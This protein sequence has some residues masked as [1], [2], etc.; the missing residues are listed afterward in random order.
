MTKPVP[1]NSGGMIGDGLARSPHM[2]L[3]AKLD[4]SQ[5]ETRLALEQAD[6]FRELAYEWKNIANES[7]A[8][9]NLAIS[10]L[11]GTREELE[12]E[13]KRNKDVC[14]RFAAVYEL[15]RTTYSANYIEEYI[16]EF[17]AKP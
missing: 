17:I 6:R 10:L 16:E 9:C 14:K 12:V 8:E 15:A 11:K 4:D 2:F 7:L 3:V 13:L 5:A 1:E